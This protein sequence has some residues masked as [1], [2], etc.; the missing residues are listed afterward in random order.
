MDIASGI[1]E[2]GA[3]LVSLPESLHLVVTDAE[4]L[5]ELRRLPAGAARQRLAL[6]ALRIGVLSMRAAGGEL[7]ARAVRDAGQQLVLEL[8]GVL[9]ERATSLTTTM[10]TTLAQYFDP[11]TGV[12]TQKLDRLTQEGGELE[13]VLRLHVGDESTLV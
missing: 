2:E 11:A 4:V 8:K 3:N 13:R 1:D 6:D 12:A 7:D 10:A 5:A 9:A